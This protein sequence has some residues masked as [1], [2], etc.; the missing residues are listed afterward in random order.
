MTGSTSSLRASRVLIGLLLTWT[1]SGCVIV[2]PATT[3]LL[4]AART[5]PTYLPAG[6]LPVPDGPRPDAPSALADRLIDEWASRELAPW[7][8]EAKVTTPRVMLA[9]LERGID[10]EAVN[11]MLL[12]AEPWAGIGSTWGLRPSGDYDFSLP[13]LTAILY[14]FGDRPDRL[15]PETREH[16]LAVLLNQ[17]G[18][19]YRTTVPGSLRLVTETENHILMTE[20]ARYL[21]NQWLRRHG[22]TSARHDNVANGLEAFLVDVLNEIDLAGPYEFNSHPY[23]GYTAMALLTLEAFAEEPVGGAARRVLDRMNY[24]YALGSHTLRRFAV[25][26]RQPNRADRT[27]LAD[28]PHTAMMRVWVSQGGGP[29]HP[30]EFNGHQAVY[31]ALMPYRLPARIR[32]LALAA[33]RDHYVRIGRGPGASPEIYA[34]GDGYLISSGGT[35][36]S[37][38]SLIVARP[39]TLFLDDDADELAELIHL[40]GAG[41]YREWNNTGVLPGF[42]VAR[43]PAHV[44]EAFT[45]VASGATWRV[46]AEPAGE[47][48]RL[49]A[50]ADT[51]IAA[52]LVV[53]AAGAGAGT[54][55]AVDVERLLRLLER[56]AGADALDGGRVVL[57]DGREVV[58]D[59]RA[60]AGE[61]VIVSVDGEPANRDVEGWPRLSGRVRLPE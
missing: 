61:W 25:F 49:I 50:V 4:G 36:R 42:A 48:R 57:P 27:H 23:A 55:N 24:E 5:V 39:I 45:P 38:L 6:E 35:G 14:R 51:G 56:D 13:P 9:K 2:R 12:A 18:G 8:E 16:L 29:D 52:A 22:S 11:A 41:D 17:E 15:Y 32:D 60:P 10:V 47:S 28:H 44:P 30:V 53:T 59:V 31:A 1:L 34:A 3:R 21:K 40:G 54:T 43:S 58:F 33:D 46:F 37:S 26:R 20:G 7:P 19:R